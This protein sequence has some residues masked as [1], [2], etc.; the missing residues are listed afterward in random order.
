METIKEWCT[1][2]PVPLYMQCLLFIIGHCFNWRDDNIPVSNLSL[3]PCFIRIRLLHLLPAVDVCK[4][5]GTPFTA[6]ISMNDEVWA[7]LYR[8]RLPQNDD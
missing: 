2:Y 4:L 8:D 1:S 6:D 5:K 7:V 3:L